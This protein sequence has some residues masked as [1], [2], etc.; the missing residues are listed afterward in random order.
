MHKGK[1]KSSPPRETHIGGYFILLPQLLGCYILIYIKASELLTLHIYVCSVYLY[2]FLISASNL[3]IR[4]NS[5]TGI[6][7]GSNI[8]NMEHHLVFVAVFRTEQDR[9]S[10]PSVHTLFLIFRRI[11]EALRVEWRNSSLHFV[12]IPK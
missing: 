9:Q 12:S 2:I 3:R 11:L 6:A 1:S 10:E 4:V 7:T 8:A 5:N